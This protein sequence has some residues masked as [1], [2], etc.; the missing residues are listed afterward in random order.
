MSSS[1][2][3]ARNDLSI[4]IHKFWE[5]ADPVKDVQGKPTGEIVVRDYVQY[6][7][8]AQMDRL[9]VVARV[10]RILTA[11]EPSSDNNMAEHAAWKRK[12]FIEPLYKAWKRGEEMPTSGMP[13]AACNFL[14]AEDVAVLKRNDVRTVEELAGLRDADLSNIKLPA[15]REKRVQAKRFLE[16]QDTNKAAAQ[17]A[18]R[19][20]QLAEQAAEIAE[21]KAT[22]ARLAAEREPAAEDESAPPRRGR[23]P[24]HHTEAAA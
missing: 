22:I 13:I 16:A 2:P 17:M 4:R 3:T 20:E 7:P 8:P 1:D 21:M 24:K 9:A 11:V 15:M 12:Q 14:R 19:D 10:D 18:A 5:E 23:P 6:G